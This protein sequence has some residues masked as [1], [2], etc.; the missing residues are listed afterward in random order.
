MRV[1]DLATEPLER[2]FG[3]VLAADA[4][5]GDGHVALRKGTRLAET[6]RSALSALQG[7]ALHVID[8]DPGEI[9]QD[10]VARR[11]ALAV[12]GPGTRAEEPAQ[13]QARVRAT[14]RGVLHVRAGAVDAVNR[15][16]PLLLFSAGDGSVVDAGDD[17]AGAKSAA[18]ATPERLVAEAERLAATATVLRVAPFVRRSVAVIVTD[19][20]E[21]RSRT[22]V[23]EA[24][25]RKIEWFGS[26]LATFTESAHEPRAIAQALRDVRAAGA[27]LILV[28]GASS[29]DPL[30]A[31]FVALASSGGKVERTG[32]PAHP[33]SM[34]WV[35]TLDAAPV[36]GIATCSG[37]GK[38]TAL[39]LLLAR[40]LSGES[41][42]SA[43]DALGARGLAEGKSPG[44][45]FPPYG[46]EKSTKTRRA[47][48]SGRD[49]LH[50]GHP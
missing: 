11:L 25:Q 36:L 7:A 26:A 12:A 19:R 33:G 29:L 32:V 20:L 48:K 37:F 35:G 46:R 9:E 14:T 2:V 28:S 49:H 31:I 47:V 34:A 40:V 39:D 6:H 21:S 8:L 44:S 42:S 3:A 16:H 10:E 23:R 50:P 27:E 30:D 13:G 18:L 22:L 1:F 45:P 4:R 5:G 41:P 38:D 17:L 15:L 43:A 24:I